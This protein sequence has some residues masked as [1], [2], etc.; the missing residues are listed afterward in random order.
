VRRTSPGTIAVV[1]DRERT[2][3]LLHQ[4]RDDGTWSLPGGR[5]DFGETFS[6]AV[7][8]EVLEETGAQVRAERLI[9]AY[10]DPA[11]FT[12]T[13]P[14]GNEVQAFAVAIEC[15]AVETSLVP[16]SNESIDVRWFHINDLPASLKARHLLIIR[17]ALQLK[18]PALG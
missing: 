1:F 4:L 7:E 16:V 8:R 13:Y 3:V 9:G 14:D 17:D 15:S 18:G 12:F 6:S 10:S 5:P 2:E 11:L